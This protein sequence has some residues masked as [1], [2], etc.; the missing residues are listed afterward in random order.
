MER[1]YEGVVFRRGALRQM[2]ERKRALFG[3]M[4]ITPHSAPMQALVTVEFQE[5]PVRLRALGFL[6]GYPDHAVEWF[7][8]AAREQE[9]TGVFVT[10]DFVSLPTVAREERGVVYAVPKRALGKRGGPAVS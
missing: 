6:Y 10:R 1:A 5:N 3:P 4:G 7:F 8:R 9:L 2:L